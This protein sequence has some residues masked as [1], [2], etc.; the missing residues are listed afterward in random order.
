MPGTQYFNNIRVTEATAGIMKA[1]ITYLAL[2]RSLSATI[3]GVLE[4]CFLTF[5]RVLVLICENLSV[6]LR[7]RWKTYFPV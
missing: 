4:R 3:A 2:R 1:R 5:L 6:H 7:K